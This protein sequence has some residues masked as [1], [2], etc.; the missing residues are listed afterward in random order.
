MA[1]IS[2]IEADAVER[3]KAGLNRDPATGNRRQGPA[4]VSNAQGTDA[5]RRA[6]AEQ[7]AERHYVRT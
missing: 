4:C 2:K 3:F 7:V 5:E 1:A 6:A